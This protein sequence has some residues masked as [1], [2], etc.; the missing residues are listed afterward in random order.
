MVAELGGNGPNIIFEDADLEAAVNTAIS[1]FIFNT[2]QFCMASTRLLVQES[3]YE[4]VL[5]ILEGAVP[6]VPVGRPSDPGTVIGPLISRSQLE[7]VEA[8]IQQALDQGGRLITGGSR[9]EQDGGFYLSP[10]CSPTFPRTRQSS[11]KR[12]SGRSS[13][14]SHSARRRRPFG[15]P[16]APLRSRGRA[17]VAEHQ[18]RAQSLGEAR[19]LSIVWVN[20]WGMLDAAVPF[21]GVGDSGWGGSQGLKRWPP[22]HAPNPSSSQSTRKPPDDRNSQCRAER[23]TPRVG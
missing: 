5:N 2:G 9:L 20:G 19:R 8:K 13:P 22:T 14:C 12:C 4:A 21:G 3:A 11:R 10:R 6:H 15:S 17:P 18:P 23:R 7:G 1:G 16:T